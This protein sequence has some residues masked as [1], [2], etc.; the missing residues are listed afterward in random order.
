MRTLLLLTLP[1][2]I[3]CSN[4]SY[5][6]AIIKRIETKKRSVS[7]ILEMQQAVAYQYYG[8]QDAKQEYQDLGKE[9]QNLVE[10]PE[11]EHVKIKKLAKH[12]PNYNFAPACM[13]NGHIFVQEEFMDH[14]WFGI[15]R[16][17]LIH[18][19]VHKKQFR[20]LEQAIVVLNSEKYQKI[21][22]EA[23]FEGAL[24]GK[25]SRCT[26]EFSLKQPRE[27]DHHPQAQ[28]YK[29]MGYATY[30]Q[31]NVVAKEQQKQNLLCPHHKRTGWPQNTDEYA[32]YRKFYPQ[33]KNGKKSSKININQKEKP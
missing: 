19:A 12:A 3:L 33:N 7:W 6:D 11:K 21:E 4:N 2:T 18:E 14:T 17:S 24:L 9:V 29:E 10:I 23:D 5:S 8:D 15:K 20:P 32:T 25:C 22:Q 31:L 28:K 16:I 26:Y 30:E 1:I 27:N 13:C